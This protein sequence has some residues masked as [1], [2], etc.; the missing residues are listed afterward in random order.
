MSISCTL[1][2]A[3]LLAAAAAAA[4]SCAFADDASG[5][6]PAPAASAATPPSPRF[7]A[8]DQEIRHLERHL[9][10]L[11]KARTELAAGRSEPVPVDEAAR[12]DRD[13]QA[14]ALREVQ[15]YESSRAK[16]VAQYVEAS[17]PGK[18]GAT[19][20]TKAAEA[21]AAVEQA[22]RAFLV[23]LAKLDAPSEPKG[24][25]SESKAGAGE[26]KTDGAKRPT[27]TT[28]EPAKKPSDDQSKRK[29]RTKKVADGSDDDGDDDEG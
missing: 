26:S 5:P 24:G 16:A 13:V 19:N 2:A 14:K 4:P 20:E 15:R 25:S 10:M 1:R 23:A 27:A 28:D 18:D 8:L 11:R 12:H 7:A 3:A 21:R 17:S 22:D 6:P 9:S 29:T